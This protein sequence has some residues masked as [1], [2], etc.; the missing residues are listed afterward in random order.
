MGPGQASPG[1]FGTRHR[2]TSVEQARDDLALIEDFKPEIAGVREV[3]TTRSTRAKLSVIGPQTQDGVTRPGGPTQLEI[4]DYDRNNPFV[5][6]IGDLI[7][8][9]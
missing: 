6:F 5:K 9:K 3:V 1:R 7:Q 8:L 2:V 4:L